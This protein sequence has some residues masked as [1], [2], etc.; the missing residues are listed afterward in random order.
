MKKIFLTVLCLAMLLCSCGTGASDSDKMQI[1][2]TM[3]PQYDFAREI[4]KDNADVELLLDFGTDAHSYEPTPADILKISKA[5]LFIYTG[6]EMEIWAKTLLESV[7][8]KK[9]TEKGTLRILDL[10]KADG[11]TLLPM[12]KDSH[13]GEHDHDHAEYDT[14]IWT[15]PKNGVK[16]CEAILSAVCK[17]DADN[18][19]TYKS[20]A[21]KYISSLDTLAK[22]AEKVTASA[23]HDTVYFGGSFAFRYLFS[24]MNLGH[25]SIYEGCS[26]HAEPSAADIAKIANEIKASGAKYILYDSPSEEKIADSIAAE[27]G[28]TVLHLHAIHNISK[29]EFESGENYLSLMQS[30]LETLRKAI[31]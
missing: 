9:A 12:D 6:D 23:L 20:N 31:S 19:D 14:H 3:F 4:V 30:N 29:A 2:A 10:S 5:D 28:I 25:V 15:S 21:E 22:A 24:D 8:I 26:S 13:A 17:I 18:A 16:M 27:C 7:D 1:I 11:I